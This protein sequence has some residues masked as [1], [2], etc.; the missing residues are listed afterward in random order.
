MDKNLYLFDMD[1]TLTPPRKLMHEKMSDALLSML[2]DQNSETDIGIISGSDL[3]YIYEQCVVFFEKVL[4]LTPET[5]KKLKIFPCN[6]TKEYSLSPKKDFSLV[7]ENCMRTHIGEQNYQNLIRVLLQ[8]QLTASTRSSLLRNVSLSGTFL[9]YRNSLI[10]WC[11]IGRDCSDKERESF[12]KKDKAEYIREQLVYE[13]EH[14]LYLTDLDS[15]MIALGGQTSID[16]YPSGWDKTFALKSYNINK[17][18]NIVFIGDKCKRG[19]N[20]F[21]IYEAIKTLNNGR[22]FEVHNHNQTKKLLELR[23][24]DIIED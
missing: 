20:D 8:C 1:G 18:K 11:P 22:S 14:C 4:E 10:N 13:L 3:N 24:L 16:I 2:T 23:L 15:L 19:Q 9:K 6:G 12:I 5:Q 21:T 7:Y 17:Y